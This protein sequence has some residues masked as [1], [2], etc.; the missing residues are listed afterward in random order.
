MWW[1]H[2]IEAKQYTQS[3]QQKSQRS[4]KTSTVEHT[5]VHD[6]HTRFKPGQ[7]LKLKRIR[8]EKNENNKTLYS[9]TRIGNK[10]TEQCFNA[11]FSLKH[12]WECDCAVVRVVGVVISIWLFYTTIFHGVFKYMCVLCCA[13]VDNMVN[14]GHM[15]YNM[16]I[17]ELALFIISILAYNCSQPNTHT[18]WIKSAKQRTMELRGDN[19]NKTRP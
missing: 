13:C 2:T 16:M 14:L 19:R 15:S 9:A 17:L 6:T 4:V 7:K 5:R 3:I 12:N 8:D 1:N 10:T 11:I 18:A